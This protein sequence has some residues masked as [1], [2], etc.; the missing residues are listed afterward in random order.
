MENKP[1]KSHIYSNI[2]IYMIGIYWFMQYRRMGRM[3]HAI[4]QF[5]F[6]NPCLQAVMTTIQKLAL[7]I[8]VWWM[9][10]SLSL[11]PLVHTSHYLSIKEHQHK[12]FIGSKRK[13]EAKKQKKNKNK[14]LITTHPV[15]THI[16]GNILLSGCIT[17]EHS[18]DLKCLLTKRSESCHQVG[19]CPLSCNKS[20]FA[21]RR[22]GMQ[23]C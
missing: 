5:L 8:C 19:M 14:T 11:W 23:S 6:N 1:N 21:V 3:G 7:I 12:P 13:G 2:L 18:P 22:Q 20:M 17:G 10:S 15:H 9:A 4:H 16:S